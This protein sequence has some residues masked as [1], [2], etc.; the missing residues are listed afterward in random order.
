VLIGCRRRGGGVE[1]QVIDTG[2]GIAPELQGLVFEEF[3]QLD[4]PARARSAGHGLGLAI[5]KRSAELLG[6]QVR[7]ASVPDTGSCFSVLLPRCERGR[8]AAPPVP[9]PIPPEPAAPAAR[10]VLLIEDDPLV[11]TAMGMVLRQQG[12]RVIATESVGEALAVARRRPPPD[13]VISDYRLPGGQDGIAG[14]EQLRRIWRHAVPASIITGDLDAAVRDRATEA[15]CGCLTKPIR[16]R[17]LERLLTE[18]PRIL[19][20]AE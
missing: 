20:A 15:G 9:V 18:A 10:T 7:L 3:C 11:L 1:I 16:P 4:N 14:V 8:I 19:V 6:T 17:D 13:L 2:P 5:V 12:C